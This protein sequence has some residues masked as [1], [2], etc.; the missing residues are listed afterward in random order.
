MAI[1][2][3]TATRAMMTLVASQAAHPHLDHRGVHR[4]VG[5]GRVGHR[6]QHLEE[7]HPGLPVGFPTRVDQVDVREHLV[8]DLDEPLRV[9]RYAVQADPLPDVTQV[10]AGEPAGAQ[11]V[12]AQQPLHDPRGRRLAVGAGDMDR[13]V[14]RL[15]VAEQVDDRGDPVQARHQVVLGRAGQDLPVDTGEP[16]RTVRLAH[17]RSTV[18]ATT[19][20][21]PS[22]S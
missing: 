7:R 13:R 20:S 14:G 17:V 10:R 8:V 18:T 4:C 6:H 9:E 16:V 3:T 11:P 1:G 21:P 5:E 19:T 22:S 15:R 2:I 12:L